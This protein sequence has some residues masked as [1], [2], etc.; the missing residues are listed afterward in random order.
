MPAELFRMRAHLS[1]DELAEE[2]NVPVWEVATRRRELTATGRP[3]RPLK[4]RP[5]PGRSRRR[6]ERCASDGR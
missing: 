4:A 2:F 6:V 5:A 3:R 1:D